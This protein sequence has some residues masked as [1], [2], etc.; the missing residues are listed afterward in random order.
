MRVG[1]QLPYEP[2]GATDFTVLLKIGIFIRRQK[3][4][5]ISIPIDEPQI[6]QISLIR[7]FSAALHSITRCALNGPNEQLAPLFVISVAAFFPAY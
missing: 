3:P 2:A 7:T 5:S 6:A 1:P 4:K